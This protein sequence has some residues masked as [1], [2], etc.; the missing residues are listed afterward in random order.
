M[1]FNSRHVKYFSSKILFVSIP[2]IIF[3][4]SSTFQEY[5]TRKYLVDSRVLLQFIYSLII[6]ISVSN[7]LYMNVLIFNEFIIYEFNAGK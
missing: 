5:M 7:Q 4:M 3:V 1:E 6:I 2:Q